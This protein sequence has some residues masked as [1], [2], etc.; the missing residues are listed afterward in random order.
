[1]GVP[2]DTLEFPRTRPLQSVN[3][4]NL[5]PV[6]F[7]R[8]G[9]RQ[10]FLGALD[11]RLTIHFSLSLEFLDFRLKD[12]TSWIY[13]WSVLNVPEQLVQQWAPHNGR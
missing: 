3:A 13:A 4:A 9:L 10:P 12:L 7:L 1:M 2:Q 8:K 5:L 6:G 11:F